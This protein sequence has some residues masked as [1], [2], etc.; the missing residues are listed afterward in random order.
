MNVVWVCEMVVM[1]KLMLSRHW[2]RYVIL[3]V[4]WHEVKQRCVNVPEG[5][6]VHQKLLKVL[7]AKDQTPTLV[8]ELH[9]NCA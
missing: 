6:K 2:T 9:N 4:H 3:L 1:Q 8:E 5:R 7:Y